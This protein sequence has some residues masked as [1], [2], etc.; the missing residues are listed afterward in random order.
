MLFRKILDTLINNSRA[1]PKCV[2]ATSQAFTTINNQ[3]R[4]GKKKKKKDLKKKISM[5][6]LLMYFVNL[7]P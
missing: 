3:T 4:K 7:I 1:Y 5:Y 2:A 6:V